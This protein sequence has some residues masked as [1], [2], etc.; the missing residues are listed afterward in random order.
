MSLYFLFKREYIYNIL[1]MDQNNEKLFEIISVYFSNTYFCSLYEQA[2]D[3]FN[4]ERY[5]SIEQA[6]QTTVKSFNDAFKAKRNI[7]GKENE[8]YPKIVN[9]LVDKY[10]SYMNVKYTLNTFVDLLTRA[11]V[12]PDTYSEI[13]DDSV[14]KADIVR[15]ILVKTLNEFT[16]YV[17]TKEFDNAVSLETR[18]AKDPDVLRKINLSWKEQFKSFLTH[19]RSEYYSLL[20]AKRNGVDIN[21]TSSIDMVSIGI[22]KALEGKLRECL[23]EKNIALQERNKM[24]NYARLLI[25]RV[26]ELESYIDEYDLSQGKAPAPLPT[27]NRFMETTIPVNNFVVQ[28]DNSN[29]EEIMPI[30]FV[31]KD[32]KPKPTQYKEPTLDELPSVKAMNMKYDAVDIEPDIAKRMVDTSDL[33]EID[34]T[35][36]IDSI[37]SEEDEQLNDED[38]M[39]SDE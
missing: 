24:A 2:R 11:I 16:V 7:H 25:D 19:Q 17:L 27:P 18:Q 12:P 39:A 10:N 8:H 31:Q 3:Y 9:K 13:Y 15:T 30:K 36:D 20:V 35:S 5:S 33:E 23:S 21:K 26:R 29:T 1:D 6:Y 14:T 28:K 37:Q 38:D 4:D 22:V 32:K 34:N